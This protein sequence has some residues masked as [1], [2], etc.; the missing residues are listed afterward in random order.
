MWRESYWNRLVVI[1]QC[2]R[3]RCENRVELETRPVELLTSGRSVLPYSFNFK[4][5]EIW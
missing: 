4:E 1:W 2:V 3:I 5:Q